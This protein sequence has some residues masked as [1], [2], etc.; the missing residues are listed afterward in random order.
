M[1]KIQPPDIIR[2]AD[3]KKLRRKRQITAA[4]MAEATGYSAAMYR[5]MESGTHTINQRA[6][7]SFRFVLQCVELAAGG[8]TQE[9]PQDHPTEDELEDLD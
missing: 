9:N 1:M 3:L 5:Q 6:S 7:N 4:N 8:V 2:P